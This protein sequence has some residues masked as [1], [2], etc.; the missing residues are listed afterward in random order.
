MDTVEALIDRALDSTKLGANHDVA[1]VFA[2]LAL[3]KAT[4]EV[5]N[6]IATAIEGVHIGS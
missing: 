6:D 2:V 4:Q 5:G 3:A 1:L